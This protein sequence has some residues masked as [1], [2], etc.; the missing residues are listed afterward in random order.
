MDYYTEDPERL[1]GQP[2]RVIADYVEQNG[3]LV[4]RRFDS[5]E[6][7]RK[8]H[9]PVLLR[10]EHPQDYDGASNLMDSF[11][12]S[13]TR[14]YMYTFKRS[15]DIKFSPRGMGSVEEIKEAYFRFGEEDYIGTPAYK[16]YFKFSGTDEEKFKQNASFSIWEAI[17]G[18]NRTVVAD[19]AI[20][21]R[22]HIMSF[23]LEKKRL[24]GGDYLFNYAIVENG[25]LIQEF[26]KPLPKDL[27]GDLAELTGIYEEIRNM[28][29]FDP[30]HCPIMEFQTFNGKNYFLQYHRARDFSP[31]GFTLDR[32]LKDGETEVLFVRGATPEEGM[33]C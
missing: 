23:Y 22:F 13:D 1:E 32:S 10:S 14:A 26:I 9:R 2:K 20:P 5:L 28:D 17:G 15:E 18:I 16:Q 25:K 4:P 30:K 24:I 33:D 3:I 19:S 6:E 8:S 27:R 12:L 29:R 31:A 11:Q 7:A 21:N